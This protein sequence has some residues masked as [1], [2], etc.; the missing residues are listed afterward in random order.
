MSAYPCPICG[1]KSTVLATRLD[2]RKRRCQ[3]CAH[4]FWT[5]EMEVPKPKGKSPLT[6]NRNKYAS[7]R[8]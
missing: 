5:Q 3:G 1:E 4:V 6:D 8:K 2:L 7:G